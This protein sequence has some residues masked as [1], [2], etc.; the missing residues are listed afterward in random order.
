MD[1]RSL[2]DL[3]E[4]DLPLFPPDLGLPERAD[5]LSSF[6]L[7]AASSSAFALSLISFSAFNEPSRMKGELNCGPFRPAWLD[8][9]E[10]L[11][12]RPRKAIKCYSTLEN[13]NR[14]N[15]LKN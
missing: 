3:L 14:S 11:A 13:P 9:R 5:A 12:L 1:D 6:S 4:A 10:G 2:D 7:R 8:A 15:S